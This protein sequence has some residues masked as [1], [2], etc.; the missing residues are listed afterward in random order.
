MGGQP[1]ARCHRLSEHNLVEGHAPSHLSLSRG[2]RQSSVPDESHSR[3]E[4]TN[5]CL[6]AAYPRVAQCLF[7]G[8]K[9]ARESLP[10]SWA[11]RRL[12]LTGKRAL[13]KVRHANRRRRQE[14]EG[15][16]TQGPGGKREGRGRGHA[17]LFWS[18]QNVYPRQTAK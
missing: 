17:D 13:R 2:L 5:V 9:R 8:D 12:A 14:M 3:S 10:H 7:F 11:I 1:G 16:A 15:R 18:T 4:S 6:S